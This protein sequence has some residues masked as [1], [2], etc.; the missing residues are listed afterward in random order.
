M[1]T[2]KNTYA[3]PDIK[4]IK[5]RRRWAGRVEC[6]GEMRSADSTVVGKPEEK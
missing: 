6:M 1:T 2:L 4:V 5:S 3:S